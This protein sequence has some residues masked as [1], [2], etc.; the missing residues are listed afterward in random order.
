M[1]E[2]M[3]ALKTKPR[4]DSGER[5]CPP[6]G[7]WPRAARRQ[8]ARHKEEEAGKVV[9]WVGRPISEIFRPSVAGRDMQHKE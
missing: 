6:C 4:V 3:S 7:Q 9:V 2:T 1:T 5:G 8:R